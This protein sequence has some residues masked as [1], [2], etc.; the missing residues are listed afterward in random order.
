MRKIVGHVHKLAVVGI[1]RTV[2]IGHEPV[3]RS[4]IQ[5]QVDFQVT[6][7][8]I[9]KFVQTRDRK[10]N[11]NDPRHG[12]TVRHQMVTSV[13]GKV[14]RSRLIVVVFFSFVYVMVVVVPIRLSPANRGTDV[15]DPFRLYQRQQP[16]DVDD[17][18]VVDATANARPSD[19]VSFSKDGRHA[20]FR[21]FINT[22]SSSFEARFQDRPRFSFE[23]PLQGLS[24]HF[25]CRA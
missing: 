24:H 18:P 4:R 17:K 10:G 1:W 8:Q 22:S 12:L 16:I 6:T 15:E 13:K 3:G 11:G 9:D 20:S 2:G 5:F 23:T 19:G 14:N 25:S 7:L 21:F